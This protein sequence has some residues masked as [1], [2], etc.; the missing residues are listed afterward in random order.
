MNWTSFS[1]KQNGRPLPTYYSE[2]IAIFQEI[3]D[4]TASQADTIEGVPRLHSAMAK[5]RVHKF[6]SGLDS[7]F[8]Q[9]RSEILCKD[10]PLDLERS[11]AYV[12]KDHQQRQTMEESRITSESSVMVATQTR[13]SSSP[14]FFNSSSKNGKPQTHDKNGGLIC[15]HYGETG[16]S[17]QR[18]YKIIGYLEWWDFTKK[19]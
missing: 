12:R 13:H 6:L 16:H 7:D 15:T 17:K 2:L 10:P 4:R 3:D 14:G 11:Y 5:H 18:C 19:P 8:N 1:T 9:V